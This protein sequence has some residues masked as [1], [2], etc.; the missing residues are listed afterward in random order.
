MLQQIIYDFNLGFW[1]VLRLFTLCAVIR[2]GT[3]LIVIIFKYLPYTV[4]T[5]L[6]RTPPSF[7][8][9]SYVATCLIAT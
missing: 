2:M 5:K 3:E 9:Y 8:V 4:P 6:L 1:P 7:C